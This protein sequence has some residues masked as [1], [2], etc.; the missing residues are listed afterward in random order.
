M[1]STLFKLPR[2]DAATA[3][4][5]CTVLKVAICKP[6][7]MSAPMPTRHMALPTLFALHR[8]N[9]AASV[10]GSVTPTSA[11]WIGLR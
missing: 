5:R 7:C 2:I 4:V 6:N 8:K 10:N 9:G 3:F 1:V 11:T